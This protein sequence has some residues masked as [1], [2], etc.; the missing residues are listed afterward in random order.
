MPEREVLGEVVFNTCMSGYQEVT[1]DPSYAGQMVVMTYPLMGNYGCRDDTAES[2]RLW[3]RALIV[4][5]LS[6]Q[7]GH[8]LA[9]R[10]LDSELRRAGLTRLRGVDTRAL[11]RHLRDPGTVRGVLPRSAAPGVAEQPAL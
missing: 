7:A 10:D 11:T 1:T 8:P 2:H 5:E 4:R 3:C 9:E 6:P